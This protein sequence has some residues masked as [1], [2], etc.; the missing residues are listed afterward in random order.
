M[1]RPD[2]TGLARRIAIE[3]SGQNMAGAAQLAL[4]QND[5]AVGN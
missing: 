2:S 5:G 3:N 4:D 1:P